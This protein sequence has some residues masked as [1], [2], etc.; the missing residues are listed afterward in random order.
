MTRNMVAGAG[1]DV[2]VETRSG[3]AELQG[4]PITLAAMKLWMRTTFLPMLRA[5]QEAS[6][7]VR[8]QAERWVGPYRGLDKRA[9][10][11]VRIRRRAM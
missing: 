5:W 4:E 1:A 7:G 3:T 6:S 8:S 2:N 9:F 11:S 10:S